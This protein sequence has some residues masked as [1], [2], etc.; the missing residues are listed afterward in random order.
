MNT[1]TNNPDY[2][3]TMSAWDMATACLVGLTKSVIKARAEYDETVAAAGNNPMGKGVM[4]AAHNINVI[5]AATRV[6]EQDMRQFAR[7]SGLAMPDLT[8]L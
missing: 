4:Q 5:G 2:A 8:A 6:L 3:E 1:A 7:S